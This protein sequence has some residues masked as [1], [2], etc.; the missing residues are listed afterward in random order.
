M[1][2]RFSI[3]SAIL[4]LV[5]TV[6]LALPAL[7]TGPNQSYPAA[8]YDARS[9][10][11]RHLVVYYVDGAASTP[12]VRTGAH[13]AGQFVNSLTGDVIG[14]PFAISEE[15]AVLTSSD[16]QPDVA[17]VERSQGGGSYCVAWA[18]DMRE[19]TPQVYVQ[20]LNADDGSLIGDNLLVSLQ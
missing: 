19:S 20:M 8:A 13:I 10:M 4:T 5:C 12:Y 6:M 17:F 3:L 11:N 9:G 7:A 14:D 1:K 2:V 16:I 15:G 18:N